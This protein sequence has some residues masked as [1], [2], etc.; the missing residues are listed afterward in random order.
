MQNLIIPK[1][2]FLQTVKEAIR[3]AQ[4][5]TKPLVL[6]V[7]NLSGGEKLKIF[8]V[9]GYDVLKS[10]LRFGTEDISIFIGTSYKNSYMYKEDVNFTY[11]VSAL[12]HE[13]GHLLCEN[14]YNILRTEKTENLAKFE[15]EVLAWLEGIEFLKQLD[16]PINLADFKD[17][18][19]EGLTLHAIAKNIPKSV[20]FQ[21]LSYV[22]SFLE[23]AIEN[24]DLKIEKDS[25]F[26]FIKPTKRILRGLSSFSREKSRKSKTKEKRT[27]WFTNPYE[28]KKY[29]V[30]LEKFIVEKAIEKPKT[31]KEILWENVVLPNLKKVDKNDKGKNS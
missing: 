27:I 31:E 6:K 3:E 14:K 1:L 8:L 22:L 21:A 13:I 7:L 25:E 16:I 12:S 4:T 15:L 23:N 5:S 29:M 17:I 18:L 28:Y 20:L 11:F 30:E 10:Y 24:G 9:K 19:T 2:Q 26:K